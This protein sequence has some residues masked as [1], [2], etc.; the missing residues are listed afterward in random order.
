MKISYRRY[1]LNQ[2]NDYYVFF[3][4]AWELFIEANSTNK[5]FQWNFLFYETTTEC[6]LRHHERTMCCYGLQSYMHNIIVNI[7][8]RFKSLFLS[9]FVYILPFLW[10][11]YR[12]D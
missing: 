9:S 7:L 4:V 3:Q 10:E 11:K 6:S 12:V 1:I 8:S 5:V 2:N